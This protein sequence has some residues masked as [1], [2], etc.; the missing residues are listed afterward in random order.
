[1]NDDD[2]TTL[3]AT[4]ASAAAAAASLRDVHPAIRADGLRAVAAEL[5]AE[6]PAL[7]ELAERETGLT[8]P[9]VTAEL[10]RTAVQLR[11]FAD[12][13]Q[14]GAYMD[15]RI[16]DPDPN[17]VL[18]TR[19]AL[20]RCLVP[21]GVVL[22]FAASNFPFAFSVAGGDTAAALAAGNAVVVKAHEGHPMLA[23]ATASITR[24]A[25]HRAGLPEG[26]LSI[27][28]GREAGVSALEDPRVD[29]ASFTGSTA[30][31]LHLAAVAAGRPRPIPF[32]GELG[33]VNPVFVTPARAR[34]PLDDLAAGYMASVSGSAGQLCTKPGFLFI[35]RGTDIARA[36]SALPPVAEHR[37]LTAAI[38]SGYRTRR[39]ILRTVPGA[40]SVLEGSVTENAGHLWAT[41]TILMT[42]LSTL[43]E[44]R[45]TLL[46][47]A[48]GPLSIVVEYDVND[49][50]RLAQVA[51]ELFPGNLTGSIHI[52]RDDDESLVREL[53][54][55]LG[56]V[57]GRVIV[58]GWPTGV[59][60][61]PAMHHG[62]P[63]PST[64]VD[65]TS[66]GTAA[67]H[68]FLRAV[69]HQDTP[70]WMLPPALQDANPWGIPRSYSHAGESIG[71]GSGGPA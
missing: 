35:P 5:E 29:A 58:N 28:E 55:T 21:L 40:R 12:V 49:A 41:P 50:S 44:R 69:A 39:D 9:R 61:T 17:F 16:D 22:N 42:D 30:G 1:M 25:L 18:G 8:R 23:R 32:F 45:D 7:L 51:A 53:H 65:A 24:G 60:V 13:A 67:I 31:G 33:S 19:P 27:I 46:D 10:A 52:A 59:V 62:G 2:Q 6:A 70:D 11:L 3:D 56:R 48:F 64:T 37:L 38:A 47:E 54:S 4:L 36:I 14:A 66:V 20:R 71:W 68:R 57:S 15:A 43:I 63:F 34:L 26:T